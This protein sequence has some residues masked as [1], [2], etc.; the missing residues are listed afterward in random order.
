VPAS[1]RHERERARREELIVTFARELAETGGWDAVTMR[2]LAERVEYSQPVLYSHFRGRAEI[3]R[4]VALRGFADLAVEL[5]TARMG[6]GSPGAALRALAKAYLSFAQSR[7]AVYDAMFVLAV[8]LPFAADDMPAEA[9]AG[10][11]ELVAALEPLAGGRDLDT[12]SEVTWAALHGLATLARSS[13]LRKGHQQERLD[14]LIEQLIRPP[15]T[16]G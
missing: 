16:P 14:L 4:A 2:R 8:D 7:P 1:E 6:A 9:R 13:R 11:T 10:F 12:L 15:S 5:G 3:V